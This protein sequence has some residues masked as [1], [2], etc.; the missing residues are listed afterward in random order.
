MKLKILFKGIDQVQIRGMK[1]VEIKGISANSKSIVPGYLFIAKR[2]KKFD[3]STFIPEAIQG[4]AAAILTDTYDPFI[5][6]T[7][8]V[9]YPDPGALEFLLAERFYEKPSKKLKMIGIT[10]TNGKTTTSYLIKYL[11]EKHKEKCGLIGTVA[12]MT[13]KRV[14]PP[15]HTTPDFL[16]LTR[17]LSEMVEAKATTGIMEVTSHALEQ[18]R[19][20]GIDFQVA[21]FTNLTHDHLDYHPTMEAYAQ[22]KALLFRRLLPSASAVINIDDPASNLMMRECQARFLTYGAT[23]LAE[24]RASDLKMTA[25]GMQFKVHYK[26]ELHVLNTQLIGRFNVSNVLASVGVALIQGMTL[27]AICEAMKSFTGVPG[28]LE[29]VPNR[30]KLQVF[31]DFAHTPDALEK[32]LKTLQE[33]KQGRI[34]TVFG[35]GG[36]RDAKKRPLMGLI[37]EKLSDVSI[38]TSDNPRGE[39]PSEI[40]RQVLGGCEKPEQTIVE[41]DREK[42]I[43]KAI[44]ITTPHDIILIAGKGH[45]TT[46]IFAHRTIHFDDRKVAKDACERWQGISQ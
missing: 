2:G 43:A 4:G 25:G 42:A 24:L 13:G 41:L 33:F 16:T 18:N 9:I 3:G 19:V 22:A 26:G 14:F 40:A 36:D 39:N 17:L 32:A 38:L 15:T 5:T 21:V 28:R 7:T 31:V 11:L 45:E 27:P 1:E 23:S 46:Q 35:C 10:G 44:E 20:Q 37:A 34:I 29:R 12:W 30:K 8:Q 6:E